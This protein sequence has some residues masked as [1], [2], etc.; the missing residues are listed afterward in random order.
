MPTPK[1]TA[2]YRYDCSKALVR[3]L[4]AAGLPTDRPFHRLRFAYGSILVRRGVPIED[5]ARFMLAL[6]PLC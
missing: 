2:Q 4:K 5:M 3:V 1:G 6:R